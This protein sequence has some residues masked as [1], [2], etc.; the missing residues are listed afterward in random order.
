[1]G[2]LEIAIIAIALAFIIQ[3]MI[4]AT[5]KATPDAPRKRKQAT[6]KKEHGIPINEYVAS[7]D[8][9][10]FTEEDEL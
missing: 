10:E 5:G 4:G 9:E 2:L 7:K 3:V 8:E 1:M 6:K